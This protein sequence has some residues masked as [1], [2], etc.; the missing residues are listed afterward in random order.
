MKLNTKCNKI[1][2]LASYICLASFILSLACKQNSSIDGDVVEA[3]SMDITSEISASGEVI[4]Q[5]GAEVK[6]GPR[7]SGQLQYLAVK[8]GNKVTKG[9]LLA[10][11]EHKDLD[12]A[13]Q[14]A[15]TNVNMAKTRLALANSSF[16][17]RKELHEKGIVSDAE[18]D[19]FQNQ[20]LLASDS[21]SQALI[22]RQRAQTECEYAVV[23]APISG[24]VTSISTLEG[25]TVA[26]SFIVPTFMTIVDT[27][28][29]QIK[30]YVDEVDIPRIK[31]GQITKISSSAYPGKIFQG[32]IASISPQAILKDNITYYVVLIDLQTNNVENDL[33]PQMT[34][35]IDIEA[36]FSKGVTTIPTTAIKTDSSG[37]TYVLVVEDRKTSQRY[38]SISSEVGSKVALSTGLKPGERI[39]VPKTDKP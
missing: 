35:R 14:E 22:A 25:E 33:R 8:V 13:L 16:Q 38:V 17:R 29:L 23:K 18:F 19:E 21:Y 5:I 24:T 28:R 27:S 1:M 26:A 2:R 11:L 15:S 10:V 37:Q 39:V 34:V 9:Q 12:L 20:H 31:S 30:A 3:G 7:I 32:V 4:P 36:G 6:V